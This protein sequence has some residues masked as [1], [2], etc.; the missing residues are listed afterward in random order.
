MQ[1]QTTANNK[2]SRHRRCKNQFRLEQ[3]IFGSNFANTKITPKGKN[4]EQRS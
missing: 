2:H 4:K 1:E 3:I